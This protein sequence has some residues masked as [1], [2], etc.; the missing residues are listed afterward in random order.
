MTLRRL[1]STLLVVPACTLLAPLAVLPAQAAELDPVRVQLDWL[2]TGDKAFFY[3]GVA[4]GIYRDAGL[5]V[6]LAPGRGSPDAV[7]QVA[8]G[9]A[10]IGAAGINALMEAYAEGGAP[11]KAV[12][13][14]YSKPPEA[15][16]TYEGSGVT[17]LATTLGKRMAY[18]MTSAPWPGVLRQAGLD[19]DAVNMVNVSPASLAPMLAQ[20]QVEMNLNWVTKQPDAESLMEAAGRKL[21]VLPLSEYGLEGY[22]YSLLASQRMIDSRPEVLARFITATREAIEFSIAHPEQAAAGLAKVVPE[23]DPAIL[24]GQ[25]RASFPLI[26][27]EI[28]QADGLGVFEP[29]RL[30]TTWRWVA[31]SDG[32]A[33]D[34]IDPAALIDSRFLDTAA[35]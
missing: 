19:P 28:S 15:V 11:V 24:E 17:D 14:I 7:T 35:Q 9:N 5:D 8:A 16:F 27:N 31:E 18:S 20:G 25:L 3:A 22:A 6:T 32:Y 10:D 30:A 29:Q 23:S 33:I 12:M 1:L 13:S 26:D 2:P 4:E 34:A 21:K